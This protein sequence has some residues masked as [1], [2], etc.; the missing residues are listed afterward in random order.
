MI[1]GVVIFPAFTMLSRCMK[2]QVYVSVT[3]VLTTACCANDIGGRQAH[4]IR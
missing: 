3:A 4:M 2:L 1:N